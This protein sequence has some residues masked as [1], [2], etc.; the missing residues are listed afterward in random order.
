MSTIATPCMDLRVTRLTQ[1]DQVAPIVSAAFAERKLVVNLLHR[2]DQS[3]RKAQLTERILRRI[4]V[5][6]P[7]SGT[8]IR[9]N[10]KKE[11]ADLIFLYFDE[12]NSELVVFH[13][14]Y[15]L[16]HI[17]VSEEIITDTLPLKQSS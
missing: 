17:D 5:A 16:D 13:W 2:N 8:A 7:L 10:S 11:L 15:K 12:V 3:T 6:D 14:K 9:V 1:R 4:L